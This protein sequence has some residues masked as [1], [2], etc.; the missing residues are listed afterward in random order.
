MPGTR[1]VPPDERADIALTNV[2]FHCHSTISDG[3]LTPAD[4]ARRAAANGVAALALT[5]H[6]ELTGLATAR[7]AADAAGMRFV[8]GVEIS[9]TWGDATVHVVGLAIDP[10]NAALVAGLGSVRS[11]RTERAKEI[12]A[13]LESI[14]IR[15]SLEGAYAHARNPALIGRTH[16]ARFIAGA[17][18]AR[19]VANVFKHYLVKGRP[20]YVPQRGAAL[21]DAVGWIRDAGGLAVIAHPGRYGLPRLE[22]ERLVGEFREAG[23]AAIEIA[24]GS[25]D[26]GH[27]AAFARLARETGLA[28]SRGSDFHAPGE[29]IEL[30]RAPKLPA[31]LEPVWARLPA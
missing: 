7:A 10:R 21:A 6:D 14:G 22:L 12:A 16:F 9:V 15:G 2:D 26:S 30:G 28:A 23:G 31:A 3:V 29:G 11:R 1:G 17:G 13:S 8:D 27:M 5:D 18:F 24:T 19:D 20:G 25:H 4:V